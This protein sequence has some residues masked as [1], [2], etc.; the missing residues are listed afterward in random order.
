M[1]KEYL[2]EIAE[3]FGWKFDR[4]HGNGWVHRFTRGDYM[5]DVWPRTMTIGIYKKHVQSKYFY[6][7]TDEKI[8]QFFEKTI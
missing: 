6:D 2:F 1:I 4:T 8:V 5:I 3:D 7:M